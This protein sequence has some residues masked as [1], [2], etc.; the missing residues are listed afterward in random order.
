MRPG[1]RRVSARGK[2]DAPGLMHRFVGVFAIAADAAI[3]KRECGYAAR[4]AQGLLNGDAHTAWVQTLAGCRLGATLAYL[5]RFAARQRAASPLPVHTPSPQPST[6]TRASPAS[7]TRAPTGRPPITNAMQL[8]KSI[9]SSHC[10]ST[11]SSFWSCPASSRA[12]WRFRSDALSGL[13]CS[14]RRPSQ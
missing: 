6:A 13:L 10:R 2:P 5:R 7:I 11:R 1:P 8:K 9:R 4:K 14:A 3:T 12:R